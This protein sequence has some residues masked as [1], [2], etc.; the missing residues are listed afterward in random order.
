M[1]QQL[2]DALGRAIQV[3]NYVVYPVRFG[4]STGLVMGEVQSIDLF[5][6]DDPT[7]DSTSCHLYK[8]RLKPRFGRAEFRYPIIVIP[9][10]NGSKRVL[11]H[12]KAG[13]L[14]VERLWESM[15]GARWL[16]LKERKTVRVQ[17]VNRTIIVPKSDLTD[18]FV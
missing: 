10:P 18:P 13:V 1:T 17:A 3:G 15:Y 16:P 6:L 14:N 2:T 8:D 12:E 11:D 9:G 5:V 7:S 4:S